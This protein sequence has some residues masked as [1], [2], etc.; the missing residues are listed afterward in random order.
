M[1]VS[2]TIGLFSHAIACAGFLTLALLLCLRR[3]IEPMRLAIA[4]SAIITAAWAA[5]YVLAARYGGD[6]GLW[7]SQAETLRTAAWVGV[8]VFILKDSFGLDDRP[9]SSFFVALMLGFVIALQLVIDS[10][11]D[12]SGALPL[13]Q[14]SAAALLFI[15]SRLV[16]AISGL[17]LVHNLYSNSAQQ[18]TLAPRLLCVGLG[19][20]FAYDLNLYTLQF[21]LGQSSADL[22]EIRGAVNALAVPIL[23][24]ATRRDHVA[25]LRISRQAAFH[26]ISFL[27]IGA[28]LIAMSLLAYGLRLTGGDWGELLQVTFLA[29]TLIF[30]ALVTLSPRFRAEMRVR[31]ARNFY[32]YRYDY[33]REW[34]RF[35]DT[36]S[37][38]TGAEPIRE[39][40]AMAIARIMESPGA[41]LLEP[42]D[43]RGFAETARWQWDALPSPVIAEGA[44]LPLFLAESGR[45]VAFDE[46]RDGRGDYAGLGLPAWAAAS[47]DIWLAIPLIRA[48][49]LCGILLLQ[50]SLVLRD[51]NWEDF[52]LLRTLGS[53]GA[54]YLAEASAQARLEESRRFDEFN[55]R[56]AFVMHDIKNLI[57]QVGLVARNAERH[58]DNPE[59]RAD[60]VATLNNSVTKMNDLLALM[61]KASG[62]A[63]EPQAGSADL[64]RIATMVIAAK[65][66]AHGAMRLEGADLPLPLP[67][68]E[69]RLEAMLTHLVQNAIDASAPEAPVTVTLGRR[70][71][72][73]ELTVADRG[74]G[75][76]A[77]FIREELFKP[78]R[79]TKTGG[80]GIGAHEA[81]E[82]VRQHGGRMEVSSTPGEGSTFTIT[83]P[84]HRQRAGR[85]ALSRT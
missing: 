63:P 25:R 28:Y 39:R 54:S 81:R 1:A 11:I 21:L 32:R 17:V 43:G 46:I 38:E 19:A 80:F 16:V 14:Q 35:I 50:R 59:F 3:G 67:G 40:L 7:L 65:R 83:L 85:P 82:I 56:F 29:T 49:Q 70:G 41:L 61:G 36:I 71:A 79:S 58:A 62:S 31:I 45:V 78:F 8:L 55:R 37:S 4:F 42:V 76:T 27:V 15:A 53:Q 23:W 33:R 75:M 6:Y 34:L 66:R 60:M 64:A 48:E 57:S 77:G 24:L 18:V 74:H 22:I 72:L 73:A 10:F 12:F 44:A 52:D 51:L 20:I 84:L 47:P 13:D 68:D 5:I 26:T 9:S 2:Q 30:G 69:G